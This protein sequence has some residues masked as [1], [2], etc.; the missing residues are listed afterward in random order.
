MTWACS[1]MDSLIVSVERLREITFD[2]AVRNELFTGQFPQLPFIDKI[3]LIP[4]GG[5]RDVHILVSRYKIREIASIQS[6][7]LLFPGN[8]ATDTIQNIDKYRICLPVHFLQ[9]D[10]DQ[11]ISLKTRAEKKNGLA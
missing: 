3:H 1:L 8:I 7:Q 4:P 5:K 2:L 6:I 9:F 10:R 11:I